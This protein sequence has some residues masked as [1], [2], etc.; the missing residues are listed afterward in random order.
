MLVGEGVIVGV[1]VG[2]DVGT[3]VGTSVGTNVGSSVSVGVGDGPA[4]GGAEAV[5][6]SDQLVA[7]AM[8]VSVAATCVCTW[9]VVVA[10]TCREIRLKGWC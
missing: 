4:V 5:S 3:S 10:T 9:P 6:V 1:S 7:E 8:A 2:M